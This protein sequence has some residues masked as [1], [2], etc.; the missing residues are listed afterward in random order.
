MNI[1]HQ[2]L[3]ETAPLASQDPVPALPDPESF[4]LSGDLAL[5]ST[6]STAGPLMAKGAGVKAGEKH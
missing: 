1:G 3:W 4:Q 5:S 2:E 6:L